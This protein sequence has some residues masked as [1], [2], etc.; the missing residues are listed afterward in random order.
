MLC[1]CGLSLKAYEYRL[2]VLKYYGFNDSKRYMKGKLVNKSVS[3]QLLV[4][5]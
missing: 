3:A 1:R 5:K 2:Y 4:N